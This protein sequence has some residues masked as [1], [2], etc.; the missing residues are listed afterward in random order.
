MTESESPRALVTGA[1]GHTGTFLLKSLIKKGYKI[2]A[3]DLKPLERR[4][5]MTKET[6]FRDD[7][8][9]EN[10][11][12]PNVKFIAADLTDKS[13]LYKFWE[14]QTEYDVVFHPAS[15]YDYFAPLHLLMKINVYG[16]RNLLE[17]IC[18]KQKESKP[19]F[20]HW[21][22][23]GVYG[24][25]KYKT[26]KNGKKEIIPADETAPYD[27]PNW[28]STSKMFQ[29]FVVYDFYKNKNVPITI[30]RPQPIAGKA[31]LYG[32]YTIFRMAYR[33]GIM[34]VPVI[35]PKY[36]QLHMPMVHVED[37]VEAAIFCYEHDETI[38]EAYNIGCDPCTQAE[39]M[40]HLCSIVDAQTVIIPI[41]NKMYNFFAKS[42]INW[43]FRREIKKAK[44]WGIRPM[45]D[46]PM[47]EYITH[48]YYFSNEKLKRL[49]FKYIYPKVMDVTTDSVRWYL[50]NGWFN[51]KQEVM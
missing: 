2:T 13:S 3:T 5:L 34:T 9:F 4:K 22:T 39:F 31:Q 17:V 14:D 12:H 50:D 7:L 32:M 28:Y 40:D 10:V 47:L 11:E 26:V 51:D 35:F 25:P 38:G 16:T 36:K 42:F 49:G 27:P 20:I 6:I 1:L 46:G 15:L 19:R 24:E 30:L 48:E 37:L 45:V 33:M 18:E 23:C 8:K 29:E 44:K 41:W 21:S 43:W